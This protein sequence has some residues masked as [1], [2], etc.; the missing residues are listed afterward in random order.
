M[1]FE[2]NRRSS[3]V[4]NMTP[5]IDIVFLLLIFSAEPVVLNSIVPIS[6]V[7]SQV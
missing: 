1:Q 4:P 7:Q 6:A 5:L 2:G 3:H